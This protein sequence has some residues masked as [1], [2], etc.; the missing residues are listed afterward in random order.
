MPD[1]VLA[2]ILGLVQAVTEF[3]P[4]SSS[5]H[6]ILARHVLDFEAVDGLTFDVALH[7]GTLLA[8]VVYFWGDLRALARGFLGSVARRS[9]PADPAGRLAWYIIAACVPAG[10]VGFFF[11][12][13]IEGY[14]RN[15]SVIVVTLLLGAFLFLWVERRFRHDGEMQALSLGQAVAIGAAQSLALIPG[16]SRS[17]ITIVVGMMC[18]LRRDQ[19]AR[20]SFLMASPLML[21]AGAKKALDLAGQ[22]ITSAQ[23]A[24]LAVGVATSAVA[25]WLV[26]RFLL[27]YLR[28]RGLDV[29]A[30][31]RIVLA[32]VVAIVLLA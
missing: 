22:S 20:F 16:V 13:A 19:A 28:R 17:G 30:Y 23:L 32:I 27:D 4:I 8:V 2:A 6:L 31:Y 26:I 25:G 10:L 3:L 29:F 15:P 9:G 5:A 12:K 11:E 1:I 21:A 14:F 24:V 7:I 18:G